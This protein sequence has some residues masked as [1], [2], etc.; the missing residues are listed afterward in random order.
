[1]EYSAEINR[2]LRKPVV[3]PVTGSISGTGM[4][5]AGASDG[6]SHDCGS[7]SAAPLGFVFL[8]PDH[9]PHQR[10][11]T[12]HILSLHY[13]QLSAFSALHDVL[14]KALKSYLGS[15]LW[16]VT[17]ISSVLVVYQTTISCKFYHLQLDESM[18]DNRASVFWRMKKFRAYRSSVDMLAPR[19]GHVGLCVIPTR[20]HVQGELPKAPCTQMGIL[21]GLNCFFLMV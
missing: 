2:T 3:D 14:F 1:M 4:L 12:T 7:L 21:L 19:E 10:Y 13:H 6:Y 16:K 8:L 20:L 17:P 11:S 15:F 18:C 9:S 5:W